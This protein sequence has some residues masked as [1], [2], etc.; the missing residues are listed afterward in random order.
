M[1]HS[2]NNLLTIEKEIQLKISQNRSSQKIPKII[3]VSKTFPM[4]SIL[5]LINHGH[6]NFGEN[7]VQEAIEKWTSIKEDFTHLKL[8]MIGKLQKN[9]VKID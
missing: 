9:K 3:A 7:K 2:V 6:L 1:D 8:H 5:P 4:S